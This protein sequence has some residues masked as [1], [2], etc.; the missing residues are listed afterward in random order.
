MKELIKRLALPILGTIIQE[1]L[2][3]KKDITFKIGHSEIRL[4]IQDATDMDEKVIGHRLIVFQN[5]K[6]LAAIR[7]E[8]Y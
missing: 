1:I 2:L 8:T 3:A 4:L 7:L 6:Q 5:D